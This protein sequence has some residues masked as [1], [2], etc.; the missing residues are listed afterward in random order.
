[1]KSQ[2]VNR[3]ARVWRLGGLRVSYERHVCNAI[4]S[5]ALVIRV[6]DAASRVPTASNSPIIV[7]KHGGATDTMIVAANA[8]LDA[9]PMSAF[10]Q[11]GT[12]DPRV[13]KSGYATWLASGVVVS[14]DDDQRC[15]SVT[16]L[17]RADLQRQS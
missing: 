7:S 3:F 2:D 12:H 6:R 14:Q 11:P 15:R 5:P 8:A 4:G 10:D 16:V 1:V 13:D 17:L 9:G